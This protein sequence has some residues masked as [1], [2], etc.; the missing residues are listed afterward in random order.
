M[1][2][3][4][5][6]NVLHVTGVLPPELAGLEAADLA[7]LVSASRWGRHQVQL[8]CDGTRPKDARPVP[9]GGVRVT[10]AG[11]GAS[12]DAAIERLLEECSHPRRITVVSNDR[13][14]QRAARRRG[15]KVLRSDDF[16]RPLATDAARAPRGRRAA[17]RRD[18][19]PLSARQVDAWLRY[20]G[21]DPTEPTP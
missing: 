8:V 4:D 19:G 2:L 9:R 12:A 7:E 13:Q 5:A 10:Y 16:L 6:Y 11:G 3:V 15:A 21:I 18:P 1:L 14:V 20:F 17:P